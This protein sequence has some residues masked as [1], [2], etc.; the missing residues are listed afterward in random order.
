MAAANLGRSP[1]A[2]APS[3]ASVNRRLSNPIPIQNL[4]VKTPTLRRNPSI[5]QAGGLVAA[6]ASLSPPVTSPHF[7][8]SDEDEPYLS[9]PSA[10]WADFGQPEAAIRSPVPV[11]VADPKQVILAMYLMKKSR[12]TTRQVWRK[13]WFY[14]TTAGITYTKSHIVS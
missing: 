8:S 13:R 4:S 5:E 3:A 9:D 1:L 10:A 11:P 14:L 6:G 2:T 7:V 12:K